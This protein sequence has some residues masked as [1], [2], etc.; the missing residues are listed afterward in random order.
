M[1]IEEMKVDVRYIV[2]KANNKNR[3]EV[4]DTVIKWDAGCIVGKED[5]QNENCW[6]EWIN[7]QCME[8]AEG[9]EVEIDHEYG[10]I[11]I[12][13]AQDKL[14]ELKLSYGVSK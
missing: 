14:D 6:R 13:E 10:K 7:P 8:K 4:G 3:F 9:M 1:K 12:K 11:K 5:K 2:T